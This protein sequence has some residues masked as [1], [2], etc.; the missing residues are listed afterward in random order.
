[1]EIEKSAG[2]LV[3]DGDKVLV[4]ETRNLKGETVYTFPKGNISK[5]EDPKETALREV[6]EETGYRCKVIKELDTV[7]Y[8]YKR[9]G[10]LIKK[11]V[12]WYIMEPIEKVR[13]HDYEVT[14]V[15]WKDLNEAQRLLSYKSD[16]G[17]LKKV[18]P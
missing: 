17:L 16:V 12:Y 1:M 11:T 8:F 13:E 9:Q 15:L 3:I 6:L 5:G 10:K 18:R 2:G 4:I 7:N 14:A